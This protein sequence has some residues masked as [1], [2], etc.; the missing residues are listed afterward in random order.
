MLFLTFL[1]GIAHAYTYAVPPLEELRVGLGLQTLGAMPGTP[2]RTAQLLTFGGDWRFFEDLGRERG[3]A[4]DDELT[5][6]LGGGRMS[7]DRLGD[8]YGEEWR[9]AALI[10][11]SY[12]G[13]VGYR[14]PQFR[15]GG[16]LRVSFDAAFVGSGSSMA[17]SY[18]LAVRGRVALGP[19]ALRGEAWASAFGRS[20]AYG[21]EVHVELGED[22]LDLHAGVN[23][24]TGLGV[25][26]GYFSASNATSTI[27]WLGVGV[28]FD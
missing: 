13:T 25:S 27:A 7:S 16:G 6:E 10:D 3:V 28:L 1:G 21:G 15:V 24:R 19:V 14:G 17:G 22:V 12:T 26:S 20:R 11:T 5:I 9:G 4:Y 23:V 18:P 8:A 2:P